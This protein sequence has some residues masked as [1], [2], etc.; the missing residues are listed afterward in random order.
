MSIFQWVLIGAFA[1]FIVIGVLIFAF[2]GRSGPSNSFGSVVVWGTMEK[3]R[4]DRFLRDSK[5]SS[6]KTV[7][8]AYVEKNE[9]TFDEDF[10][11]ALASQSGPD[12]FFLAENSIVKHQDK[13]VTIPFES[14]SER[15]FKENFIEEGEIY[16]K[17]DG[18]IALPFTVDPMVMYWNRDTFSSAGISIPPKNWSELYDLSEKLTKKDNNLNITESAVALGEYGNVTHALE[19]FSLLTMQAGSPIVVRRENNSFDNIFNSPLNFPVPPAIR[20]LSFYTEFSNPLKPFYSWNRSLPSSKSFFLSGNLALYFGFASEAEDLRQ[21]NPNLN[22]DVA[23]ILQ[24]KDSPRVITFGRMNG[25]AVPKNSKNIIGAFKAAML[26]T[27]PAAIAEL[28]KA[29]GL[30]P[31]HRSLLLNKPTGT[32]SSVF[33]DGAIQARGW[34]SPEV[35]K[36]ENVF[37]EMIESVTGGRAMPTEAISKASSELNLLLNEK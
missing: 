13:V 33:Y 21:K 22:F 8:I 14:Y 6:D 36:T 15:K 28:S 20:A 3:A 5:I 23:P 24:S 12:L 17:S 9:A 1:V 27:T 26:M 29:T 35:S 4:F 34:L 10:I 25:L 7:A 11:E 31:V 16:L 18:A 32:F 2:G 30:P 37:R 19:L